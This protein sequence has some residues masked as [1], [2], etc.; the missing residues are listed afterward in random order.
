MP[1]LFKMD[2]YRIYF[3]SNEGQPLEPIHVHVSKNQTKIWITENGKCVVENNNSKISDTT[4]KNITEMIE[5]HADEIIEE[6][7]NRFKTISFYC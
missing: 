7:K 4:L 3:W 2:G 6:W 1:Q 5:L